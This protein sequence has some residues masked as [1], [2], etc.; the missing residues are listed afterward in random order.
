M[1]K[2]I[3]YFFNLPINKF[4]ALM[5]LFIIIIPMIIIGL[6]IGINQIDNEENIYKE[7]QAQTL[8]ILATALQKPLY[9]FD[10]ETALPLINHILLDN[11]ISNIIVYDFEGKIFL[12]K[13]NNTHHSNII[14]LS[15]EITYADRVIGSVEIKFLNRTF[16]YYLSK[17][18]MS[19]IILSLLVLITLFIFSFLSKI[20][21]RKPLIYLNEQTLHLMNND[22]EKPIH[23]HNNDELGQLAKTLEQMRL[24]LKTHIDHLDDLVTQ[25]T[26]EIDAI[27]QTLEIR[28]DK[29]IQ[30]LRTKDRLL[31]QQSKH[32][33]MGEMISMIAH[34]WRQPLASISAIALNIKVNLELGKFDLSTK[35][36]IDKQHQFIDENL[37]EIN[38]ALHNLSSTIDDFRNFYKPN[39]DSVHSNLN[40]IILKSLNIFNI[41]LI[42]KDIEIRKILNAT[43]ELVLFDNEMVHVVLNILKNAIDNFEEKNIDNPKITIRAEDNTLSICDNGGGVSND[44]ID[45][46]FDP[47]FS[48]KDEKNGTGIGLY[49]SK[50]I[51]EKHHN[52]T[53]QVNNKDDGVCFTISFNMIDDRAS[54]LE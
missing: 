42:N 41:S 22:L 48:T 40:D 45:K 25:R 16:S 15:K 4:F 2:I 35:E 12:K 51:I 43:K 13:E 34:Q 14:T 39:K 29:G 50:I 9:T 49:M 10:N 53:L 47:Y 54:S 36:G 32:A 7:Y 5:E 1:P 24:S 3:S 8:N 28:V 23:P 19:I 33:A 18:L 31:L 11:R 6:L 26:K 46:I 27:N 20:K 21:I 30:E 44:I 17:H 38:F 52:A 37:N